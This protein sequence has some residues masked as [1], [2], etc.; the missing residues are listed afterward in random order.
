MLFSNDVVIGAG[1]NHLPFGIQ[2]TTQRLERPLKYEVTE[3]AERN[4]IYCAARAGNR[5][6]GATL[7]C[8][9]A[10]CADCARGIIQAGIL[11]LV[12][13]KDATIRGQGRN[14]DGTI[15]IA[16]EMLVEAGVEIT[17]IEGKLTTLMLRHS[18]EEWSP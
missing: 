10:A 17:D 11:R 13:H 4:A 12:R 15:S 2:P 18:G 7:Y 5:T 16:D 9:W 14:W 3:H 1:F 6:L 8:P